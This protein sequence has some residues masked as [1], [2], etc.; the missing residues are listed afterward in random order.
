MSLPF[1]G[2]S[3]KQR[4]QVVVFDLGTNSTKAVHLIRKGG[5]VEI[6]NYVIAD[7][8]DSTMTS[9]ID[10]GEH[11][12]EIA[13]TIG[14]KSKSVVIALGVQDSIL[15]RAEMPMVPVSDMRTM[16]KVGSKNYLQQD[17]KEHIYDCHIIPPKN[18]GQEG[19]NKDAPKPKPK[20]DVLVG[21]AP[22]SVIEHVKNASKS[23]GLIPEQITPN[24]V[25][26]PNAFERAEPEAFSKEVV[27]LVD[28]GFRNSTVSVLMEGDLVL[29]RVLSFGGDQ[30]TR[31]LADSLGIGYGEAE[32]IKVGLSMEVKDQIRESLS[33]LARELR[34]SID[35][36]EHQHDRA[37]SKV[38]ISGGTACSD[39][40][41]ESL[42]AELITPCSR[43]NPSTSVSV[44]LPPAAMA[45]FEESAPRLAVAIGV[46]SASL[47]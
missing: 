8:P 12:K 34:A 32:G 31:A 4:S 46:G 18:L 14:A 11:L 39:D 30:L 29:N 27:A 42:Q 33:P 36:F 40:I 28:I 10:L 38:F 24:L 43:W 23:A 22:A 37:I 26:P 3:K 1:L 17:L 15:R 2:K 35:F 5:T 7:R 6:A 9:P 25:G 47:N 13:G 19:G 21:G 44:N 16:L 45:T 41:I 20:Y